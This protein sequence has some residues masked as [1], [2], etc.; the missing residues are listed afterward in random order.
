M[1]KTIAKIG[2]SQGIILDAAFLDLARLRLGDQLTVTLHEGGAIVMT[3]IRTTIDAKEAGA[4][5]KRLIRR[6]SKLFQRLS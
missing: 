2:N 3:P 4:K 5:A 1:T 6:N